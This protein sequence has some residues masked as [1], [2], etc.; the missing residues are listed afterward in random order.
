MY[1]LLSV[2]DINSFIRVHDN[3]LPIEA[4][5]ENNLN[6]SVFLR[7]KTTG[8]I[9]LLESQMIVFDGLITHNFR[10][11]TP[12]TFDTEYQVLLEDEFGYRDT[13]NAVT[14][15]EAEV[16]PPDI[17]LANCNSLSFQ[18]EFEPVNESEGEFLAFSVEF[19]W[20]GRVFSARRAASVSHQD[21]RT[22]LTFSI[23]SIFE[24]GFGVSFS[25]DPLGGIF[26]TPPQDC[27][28]YPI[29]N[30]KFSYT[31]FGKEVDEGVRLVNED[32]TIEL[33]FFGKK[34]IGSNSGEFDFSVSDTVFNADYWSNQ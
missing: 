28:E 14:P 17:R 9:D 1:G 16:T 31:H 22:I 19:E 4:V 18:I 23:I 5:T 13:V 15:R 6:V 26:G 24:E 29:T 11:N 33:P 27:F 8:S 2:S 32:G 30:Y 34:V 20:L 25:G 3:R 12:L 7:N 21:N 10:T